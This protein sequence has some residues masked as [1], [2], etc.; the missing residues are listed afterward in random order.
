MR[1]VLSFSCW[2][3]CPYR[4]IC[5]AISDT[6]FVVCD[7]YS[8][9]R[10]YLLGLTDMSVLSTKLHNSCEVHG[11][12]N[13]YS[14]LD[15]LKFGINVVGQKKV[16]LI[17]IMH[18]Y[19]PPLLLLLSSS[20]CSRLEQRATVKHFVSL[21]FLNLRQSIRLL[22]RGNGPSQG[23]CLNTRTQKQNKSRETSMLRSGFK[24][25]FQCLSGRRHFMPYTERSL[26]S[27]PF[28]ITGGPH[29]EYNLQCYKILWRW[30]ERWSYNSSMKSILNANRDPQI[31]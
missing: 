2:L 26:W 21:Q 22:G 1:L 19:I 6:I 25:R 31:R 9:L 24:W 20:C 16:W 3:Q 29:W 23:R 12:K 5:T 11:I 7:S 27:S 14:W 13:L 28:W 17:W 10:L 30:E 4:K 18:V 8:L 15:S